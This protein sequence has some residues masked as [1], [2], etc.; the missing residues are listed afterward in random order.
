MCREK[1][2]LLG[3]NDRHMVNLA[4]WVA[5]SEALVELIAG[6]FGRVAPRRRVR[7]YLRGLSAG[8]ETQE[9]IDAGRACRC[10]IAG[11]NT[12]GVRCQFD[13]VHDRLLKK[14]SA[15]GPRSPSTFH[16]LERRAQRRITSLTCH[17]DA[18]ISHG[19]DHDER[20]A[21]AYR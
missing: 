6:R 9:W 12:D 19:I 10:G 18:D 20:A 11:W 15:S 1:C 14:A 5:G 21:L 16:H 7:A 3:D 8:V 2:D 4:G 17:D 13:V